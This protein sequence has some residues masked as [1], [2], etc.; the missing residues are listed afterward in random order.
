MVS[1]G[2]FLHLQET[3]NIQ[4][5]GKKRENAQAELQQMENELKEKLEEVSTSL[6]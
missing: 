3:L 6:I 2:P 5:E 1:D 4:N